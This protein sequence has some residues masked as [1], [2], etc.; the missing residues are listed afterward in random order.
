MN[1]QIKKPIITSSRIQA[2]VDAVFA[3]AMTLL[4]LNIDV[5]EM[6]EISAQNLLGEKIVGMLPIFY[7]FILSFLLLGIFWIMHHRHF[8]IIKRSD[9]KLLWIN[10]FLLL[11]I[12]LV[13]FSSELVGDYGDIRIAALFF[14]VNL[15]VISMIYLWQWLYVT[16]N[17]NL[18]NDGVTREYINL[19][20][21]K[22]LIFPLVSL[23]A[24]II[25]FFNPSLSFDMYITIP[26]LMFWFDKKY[27]Y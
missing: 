22:N 8:S 14:N 19:G 2:L 25:S 11:S 23:L 6:S 3:I 20:T 24:I 27:K 5:P 7:N 16:N 13:P 17:H 4:V 1:Q 12:V 18:I 9:E 26:F 10:L 21:I 15:F